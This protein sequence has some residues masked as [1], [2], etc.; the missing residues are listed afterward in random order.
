[1]ALTASEQ[2]DLQKLDEIVMETILDHD[3]LQPYLQED[4]PDYPL[5][6]WWWHLG[7]LRAGA[8]PA[9][10]LPAHLRAIYQPVE[11]RLVA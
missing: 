3:D 4:N 6:Q 2:R 11:Q 10:L 7:K 9:H 1:M 5:T 8:Y